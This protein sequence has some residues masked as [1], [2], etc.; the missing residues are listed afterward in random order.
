MT[1]PLTFFTRKGCH[2]CDVALADLAPFV[3]SGRVT[4]TVVDLDEE[5]DRDKQLAYT[6]DVPV[7]ELRGRKI[8]KYRIDSER[9]ERLLTTE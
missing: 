9:L 7:V 8:M 6:N 5:A 3:N 2:L 1:T 4:V